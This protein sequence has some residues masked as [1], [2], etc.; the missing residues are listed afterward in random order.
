MCI[1]ED[2]ILIDC[3]E[4]RKTMFTWTPLYNNLFT[5]TGMQALETSE[6]GESKMSTGTQ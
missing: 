1:F 2:D 3:H 4:K 5:Q 6:I